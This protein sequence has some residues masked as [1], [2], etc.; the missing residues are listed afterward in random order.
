MQQ[1]TLKKQVI[2]GIAWRGSADIIQQVLQIVFTIILARLLTR[3]DF[4]LVAMALIVNRFVLAM[5]S[6]GFGAAIIHSQD[7]TKEQI[8]AVFY[9][10][11]AL[12]IVLTVAVYLAAGLAA[13]FFEEPSLVPIIEMMALVIFLQTFQF[14]NILL[15][16]RMEFKNFSIWDKHARSSHGVLFC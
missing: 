10:Q 8:S 4:G 7:I 14:P 6:I 15:R 13:T 9:I 16:K 11:L 5:T 1:K 3:G 2:G 12:N